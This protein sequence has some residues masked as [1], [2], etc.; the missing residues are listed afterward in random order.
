M[1]PLDYGLCSQTVTI[2]RKT[3]GQVSRKVIKNA[4]L[5]AKISAPNE[6]YGKSKEKQFLLIIPGNGTPLQPGDR[7]YDGIGPK[8]VEWQSFV[9][10]LVSE[11]YEAAFAKP[12]CWMGEI[13]HWEAGNRKEKL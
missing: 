10:A 13:T 9:P 8:T 7:V 2:Y 11:L 12:C 5:S 3:G 4:S 6:S 1:N